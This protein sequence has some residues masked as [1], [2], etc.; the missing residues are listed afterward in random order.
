[1]QCL[2]SPRLR[3]S[4]FVNRFPNP[5][6]LE[7]T[8]D[9][10]FHGQSLSCGT[11]GC[12][13]YGKRIIHAA[14]VPLTKA[15]WQKPLSQTLLI[16]SRDF[17]SRNFQLSFTSRAYS[18]PTGRISI[19]FSANNEDKIGFESVSERLREEAY[20]EYPTQTAYPWSER[21]GSK[22]RQETLYQSREMV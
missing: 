15:P 20:L 21:R 11:L 14:R 12:S 10:L 22:A 17:E 3:N 4:S 6:N 8:K 7:I 9:D 13:C 18:G 1:M 5:P 2:A 16:Q 19:P